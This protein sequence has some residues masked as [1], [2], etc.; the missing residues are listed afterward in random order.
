MNILEKI[1]QENISLLSNEDCLKIL[2]D[3]S[4]DILSLLQ[5]AYTLRQKYWEKEVQIHIINNAQN[6]GCSEDCNYC[7]QAKTSDTK[8]E[9]YRLKPDEESVAEAK[10]AYENGAHR[11]C[12]V[13]SG[14]APSDKRINELCNTIQSIK[15]EVPVEICLSA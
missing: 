3:P 11:Y 10:R 5:S 14:R 12:M 2:S 4:L 13:S 1:I 8:I 9:K 7:V 15:H 6:G